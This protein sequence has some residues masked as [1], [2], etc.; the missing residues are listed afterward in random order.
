MVLLQRAGPGGLCFP[1]GFF[2]GLA[3]EDEGGELG[4]SVGRGCE[5]AFGGGNEPC[6][7]VQADGVPQEAR[8]PLSFLIRY[9]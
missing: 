6:R 3:F 1:G 5:A 9:A 8:Y 2:E 7:G 4:G